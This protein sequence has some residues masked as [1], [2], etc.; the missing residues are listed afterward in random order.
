MRAYVRFIF[1]T[2]FFAISMV[3][4]LI[5]GDSVQSKSQE[6]SVNGVKII[7]ENAP[8]LKDLFP[9]REK[10][11]HQNFKNAETCLICHRQRMEIPEV[12][13]V[14]KIPHLLKENCIECHKLP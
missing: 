11:P 10:G 12:G 1:I 9:D 13:T 4:V 2:F 5:L 14:P 3:Y 6:F 8:R 7:A